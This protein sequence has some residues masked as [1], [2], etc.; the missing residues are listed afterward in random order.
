MEMIHKAIDAG[1]NYVD[2]AYPYHNGESESFVGRILK[3][4]YRDQVKP[5]EWADNCIECGECEEACPQQIEIID[6]LAK[7]HEELVKAGD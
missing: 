7:A 1:V 3:D 6:W 2:T 5:E 4:G